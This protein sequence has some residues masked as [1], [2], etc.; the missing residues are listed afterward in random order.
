M[1]PRQRLGL[2]AALLA[3]LALRVCLTLSL[4][5]A[6]YFHDPIVDGAAYD[7]WAAEIAGESFWGSKVFYQDP[8]YPY[9]LGLVYKVF[10]RD[11]LWI[12][13]LQA[14]IGT[15][16]LWMLFEAVR[17][18]TDFRTALLAL[19]MG[20]LYKTLAFF[21]VAV[22]KDFLGVVAIE[23]ARVATSTISD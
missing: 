20:A 7:R 2:A 6:P 4:R 18:L 23:A 19:A 1:N 13:L 16:G 5:D 3:A 11:L 22:L 10:G 9:A 17:S 12:R 21:D 14:L 15:L 8:L